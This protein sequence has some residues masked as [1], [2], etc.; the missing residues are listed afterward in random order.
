M[1]CRTGTVAGRLQ[2]YARGRATLVSAEAMR[3]GIL[4]ACMSHHGF[5]LD[6]L[7]LHCLTMAGQLQHPPLT[8]A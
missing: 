7:V 8:G 2:L 5:L 4:G 6:D 1:P 3:R